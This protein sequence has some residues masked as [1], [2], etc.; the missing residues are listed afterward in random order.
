MLL[1]MKTNAAA[2]TK[3]MEFLET[4]TRRWVSYE[5]ARSYERGNGMLGI[6]IHSIPNFRK[7]VDQMGSNPFENVTLRG[8]GEALDRSTPLYDWS[9]DGGYRNLGTWIDRAARSAG[10]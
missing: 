2:D 8:T 4:A 6:H 10:R 1:A 9:T 5:I 3:G 7:E